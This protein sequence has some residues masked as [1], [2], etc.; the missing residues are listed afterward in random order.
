MLNNLWAMFF[1]ISFGH[2]CILMQKKINSLP[3]EFAAPAAV[4]T[5]LGSDTGTTAG[6]LETSWDV[7]KQM[8]LITL[9]SQIITTKSTKEGYIF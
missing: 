4:E 7:D 2:S 6:E 5:N 8:Q 3:L 9:V 1:W